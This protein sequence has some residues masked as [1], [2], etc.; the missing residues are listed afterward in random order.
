MEQVLRGKQEKLT[1]S[2]PRNLWR[3]PSHRPYYETG[4]GSAYLGDCLKLIKRLPDES[5]NL[6]VTSPPFALHRQKEYGNVAPKEYVPWFSPFADEFHRV[7][8][9]D[10]SLV[11]HIGGTWIEGRPSKSLYTYKLL[12]SLCE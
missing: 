9:D 11:I 5:V 4:L 6:I 1:H 7:L 2:P 8:S 3:L 12:L 10:G